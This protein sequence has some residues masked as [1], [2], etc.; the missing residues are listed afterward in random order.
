MKQASYGTGINLTLASRGFARD[1][2]TNI[3]IPSFTKIRRAFTT[4]KHQ[5][6]TTT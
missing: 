1:E 2:L 6:I 3:N 5:Y 4:Y